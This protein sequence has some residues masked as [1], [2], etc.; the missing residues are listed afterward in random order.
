MNLR[1]QLDVRLLSMLTANILMIL[2]KTSKSLLKIDDDFVQQSIIFCFSFSDIES[3]DWTTIKSTLASSDSWS[4]CRIG[5]YF[6]KRNQTKRRHQRNR[7]EEKRS[8][9]PDD[10]D[11][12]FMMTNDDS[13]SEN[14]TEEYDM[15]D[16]IYGSSPLFRIMPQ[17]ADSFHSYDNDGQRYQPILGFGE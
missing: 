13:N 10:D 8:N 7:D 15:L 11:S 9:S 5:D 4:I 2:K 16:D 6:V 12:D 17:P 3:A 14:S 1:K